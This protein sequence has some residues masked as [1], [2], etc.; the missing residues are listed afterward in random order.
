MMTSS[1]ARVGRQY[2]RWLRS[3]SLSSQGYAFLASVPG[4]LLINTP[5]YRFEKL[6]N[7]KAEHRVLDVGCGQ[8]SVLQVLAAR[9]PFLNPPVGID[10]SQ[11]MIRRAAPTERPAVLIKGS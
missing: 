4:M 7:I 11:E 8:G 5:A 9:V 3:G 1:E 6:L 10:L 2:D